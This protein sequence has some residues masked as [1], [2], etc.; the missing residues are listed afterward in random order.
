MLSIEPVNSFLYVLHFFLLF[1]LAIFVAINS[2]TTFVKQVFVAL[3]VTHSSLICYAL[4]YLFF[5]ASDGGKIVPSVVYFGFDNIRFFNQVQ[6]FV[7]PALLFFSWSERFG[8]LALLMLFGNLLLMYLGGGLGISLVWALT[9]L[10]IAFFDKRMAVKGLLV[11]VAAYA[12]M[13]VLLYMSSFDE[14]A[15]QLITV[16]DGGRIP[17]WLATIDQLSLMH[18][19][20]GIGPGLFEAPVKLI[21][22][23]HPHNSILELLVEWGG[24]ATV[25]MI[26][27]VLWT[28][29]LYRGRLKA[30]RA[31]ELIDIAFMSFLGALML[32]LVSGVI[33]MP[34]A[35]CLLFVF[36]GL[37]LGLYLGSISRQSDLR[38]M[39]L[40]TST[41]GSSRSTILTTMLAITLLFIV[42][43]YVILIG[44]SYSLMDPFAP[45]MQGPRFWLNGERYLDLITIKNFLIGK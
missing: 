5:A 4:L 20:V 44:I 29:S 35:Q 39:S 34:M 33:V 22:L 37:F 30:N 40:K 23:S 10:F 32:S 8:R 28:L 19:L 3:V 15:K 45:A 2:S 13:C 31:V 26:G 9:L 11:S 12:L 17:L 36:W 42:V 18:L 14:S 16:N 7:L 27:I 1:G 38:I 41:Q 21:M 24:V 6:V 25:A 43:A